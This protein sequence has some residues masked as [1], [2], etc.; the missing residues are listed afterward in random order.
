MQIAIDMSQKI[1]FKALT[2]DCTWP[3]ALIRHIHSE[4]RPPLQQ[5]TE[6]NQ[7]PLSS[8]PGPDCLPALPTTSQPFTQPSP[9]QRWST[10]FLMAGDFADW[11]VY[12]IFSFLKGNSNVPDSDKISESR[13]DLN[14]PCKQISGIGPLSQD[15]NSH[16][17]IYIL[18]TSASFHK[19]QGE[20]LHC[21]RHSG[22]HLS[23][24]EIRVTGF[25]EL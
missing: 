12:R 10:F 9:E 22:N 11:V 13:K 16:P 3:P 6:I 21:G 19:V 24:M 5:N 14:H 2:D 15:G 25:R 8:S 17:G 4:T 1:I 7:V 23:W 18:E 20:Q